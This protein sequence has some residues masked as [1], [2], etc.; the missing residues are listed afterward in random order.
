MRGRIKVT[1]KRASL[2]KGKATIVGLTVTDLAKRIGLSASTLYRKLN[3]P[4]DITLGE[5]E[6]IDEL[7]RFSDEEVL[8]FIRWRRCGK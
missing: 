4:G 7:V 2:I 6:L 1:D 3:Y 8:Y 5:L